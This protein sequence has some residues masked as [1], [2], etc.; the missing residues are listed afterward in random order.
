MGQF[1]IEASLKA[2]GSYETIL[3]ETKRSTAAE[4]MVKVMA[5]DSPFWRLALA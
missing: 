5:A 4:K 2:K 3:P 1:G